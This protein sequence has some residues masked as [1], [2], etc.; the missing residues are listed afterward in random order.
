MSFLVVAFAGIT[1]CVKIDSIDAM[2]IN[3]SRIELIVNGARQVIDT[4]TKTDAEKIARYLD[5][6]GNAALKEV[7]IIDCLDGDHDSGEVRCR[8]A[9]SACNGWSDAER[10]TVLAWF[11]IIRDHGRLEELRLMKERADET[12]EECERMAYCAGILG[13]ILP[14]PK[15]PS[16]LERQI[17]QAEDQVDCAELELK[18]KKAKL[19]ALRAKRRRVGE[20]GVE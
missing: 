6:A 20:E 10:Q 18:K 5:L 13:Q 7:H 9:E 17:Y 16:E 2:V 4:P 11:N 3:Q 19:D 15:P 8:Y 12:A 14:P 1:S